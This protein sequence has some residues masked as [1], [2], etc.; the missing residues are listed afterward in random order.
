[1]VLSFYFYFYY[2]I[3]YSNISMYGTCVSRGNLFFSSERL[4]RGSCQRASA[5]ARAKARARGCHR[6]GQSRSQRS[7]QRAASCCKSSP[8][9]TLT[10][11]PVSGPRPNSVFPRSD[12]MLCDVVRLGEKISCRCVKCTSREPESQRSRADRLELDAIRKCAN[13][14]IKR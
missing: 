3:A 9:L 1:M 2:P 6:Y 4:S 13:G 8:L 10:P 14:G 5:I 12:A 11:L 7:F